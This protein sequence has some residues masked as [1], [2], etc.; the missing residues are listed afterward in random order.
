MRMND[1]RKGFE[2]AVKLE[3]HL[4]RK[5]HIECHFCGMEWESGDINNDPTNTHLAA[6]R[7]HKDGWREITSEEYNVIAPA[8]PNCAK[9]VK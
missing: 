5:F 6:L 4:T 7:I 1:T 9:E 8:C 3:N 2:E